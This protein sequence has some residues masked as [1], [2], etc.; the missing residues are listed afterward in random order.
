V[1]LRHPRHST[2]RHPLTKIVGWGKTNRLLL[3]FMLLSHRVI[4]DGPTDDEDVDYQDSECH[5]RR[6]A[7]PGDAAVR[8]TGQNNHSLSR[9]YCFCSCSLHPSNPRAATGRQEL[10]IPHQS[11]VPLLPFGSCFSMISTLQKPSACASWVEI[12]GHAPAIVYCASV[13]PNLRCV[14]ANVRRMP[15]SVSDNVRRKPAFIVRRAVHHCAPLQICRLVLPSCN[16]CL[17]DQQP[18][19]AR[20]GDRQRQYFYRAD[21]MWLSEPSIP[22]R[23]RR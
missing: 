4:T 13:S 8:G 1:P 19:Q 23:S 12:G 20:P 16:A 7:D 18:N 3:Q 6:G 15:G 2:A 21:A 14:S 17:S 9:V 22:P 5:L 10:A 11:R